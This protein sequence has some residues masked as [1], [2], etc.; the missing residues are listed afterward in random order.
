[1]KR[2]TY[3]L[4]ETEEFRE[5]TS[6]NETFAI[7]PNTIRFELKWIVYTE[8]SNWVDTTYIELPQH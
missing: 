4:P 1:M 8:R 7:K 5:V 6:I 3:H 2:Y